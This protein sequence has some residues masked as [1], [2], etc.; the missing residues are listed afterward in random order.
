MSAPD[1]SFDVL[2]CG[3]G[4]VGLLTAYGLQRM[5]IGTC[6]IGKDEIRIR[7]W[8]PLVR[9]TAFSTSIY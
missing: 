4:P 3:G 5:G 9:I 7:T 8:R 6:V 1:R 2:V